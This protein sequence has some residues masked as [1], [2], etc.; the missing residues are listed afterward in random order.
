M[1]IHKMF[2]DISYSLAQPGIV[3]LSFIFQATAWLEL[4]SLQV[5]N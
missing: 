2:T 1:L 3:V 4:L 5:Y